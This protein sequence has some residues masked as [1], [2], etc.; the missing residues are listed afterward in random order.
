MTSSKFVLLR[1]RILSIGD[2]R[3]R[4]GRRN[5]CAQRYAFSTSSSSLKRDLYTQRIPERR[6]QAPLI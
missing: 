5:R 1:V 3:V 6:R 4:I 2:T